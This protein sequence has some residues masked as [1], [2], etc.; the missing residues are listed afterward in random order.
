[1]SLCIALTE[2]INYQQTKDEDVNM[3]DTPVAPKTD[4]AAPA[5]PHWMKS[6]LPGGEHASTISIL[7]VHREERLDFA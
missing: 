4:D 1:M 7:N 3:A 5:R 2:V 6:K